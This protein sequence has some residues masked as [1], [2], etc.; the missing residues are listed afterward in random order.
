MKKVIVNDRPVF[1][2]SSELDWNSENYTIA[3]LRNIELKSK[4]DIEELENTLK[5]VYPDLIVKYVDTFT[6][7]G[8][9]IHVILFKNCSIKFCH[10]RFHFGIRWWYDFFWSVNGPI[11]VDDCSDNIY[12]IFKKLDLIYYDVTKITAEQKLIIDNLI[13]EL[14][15]RYVDYFKSKVTINIGKMSVESLQEIL[16]LERNQK[17]QIKAEQDRLLLGN[18]INENDQEYNLRIELET[19]KLIETAIQRNSARY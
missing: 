6:Y 19:Q 5:F 4:S 13:D 3:I 16:S 15:P 18:Y 14:E 10:D 11:Y 9:D 7:D 1:Q 8:E 2:C 12:D 17:Y